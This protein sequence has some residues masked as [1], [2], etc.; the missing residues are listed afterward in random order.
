MPRSSA[1]KNMRYGQACILR[2]QGLIYYAFLIFRKCGR[3]TLIFPDIKEN[4]AFE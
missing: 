2:F 4:L 3:K 1:M